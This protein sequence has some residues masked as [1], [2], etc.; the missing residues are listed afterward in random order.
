[1]LPE[2]NRLM[3]SSYPL[4]ERGAGDP[5]PST[6]QAFNV[7]LATDRIQR[8]LLRISEFIAIN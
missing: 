8:S 7:G 6:Q 2:F 5:E 1:M 4:P 3:K